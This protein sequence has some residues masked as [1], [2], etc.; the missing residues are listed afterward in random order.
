[1]IIEALEIDPNSGDAHVNIAQSYCAQKD[2]KQAWDHIK[3]AQELKVKIDPELIDEM[4]AE[5]PKYN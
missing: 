3:K 2:S 1:M 5:C 4:K